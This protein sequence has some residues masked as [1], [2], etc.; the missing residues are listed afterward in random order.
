MNQK[1]WTGFSLRNFAI[2]VITLISPLQNAVNF[3]VSV[4][5]IPQL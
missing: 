4:G 2:S 1:K 3:L 5:S